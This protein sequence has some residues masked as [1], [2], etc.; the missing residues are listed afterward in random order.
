MAK[1]SK[2]ASRSK[3]TKDKSITTDDAA[4]TESPRV[5]NGKIDL[6]SDHL[7]PLF[8]QFTVM[9]CSGF[10]LLYA[11]RDVFATG[12]NIGGVYDNAYLVCLYLV[13]F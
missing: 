3:T 4:K 12:R 1:S 8:L 2:T 9:A 11:F 10:L 7:P 6:A 5:T 13:L